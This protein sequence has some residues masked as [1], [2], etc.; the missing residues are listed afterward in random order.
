MWF[1]LIIVVVCVIA[2]M[3]SSSCDE[4]RVQEE[5]KKIKKIQKARDSLILQFISSGMIFVDTCIFMSKNR[6]FLDNF[7]KICIKNKIKI[8]VHNHVWGE[9]QQKKNDGDKKKA[10]LARQGIKV[11]HKMIDEELI[12]FYPK[13]IF[14]NNTKGHA[15]YADSN[16]EQ[17]LAELLEQGKEPKLLTN[18]KDLSTALQYNLKFPK[19]N[20]L[21]IKEWEDL[22]AK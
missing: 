19:S 17:D 11:I 6:D 9:L 3:D 10:Y 22:A 5:R 16:F 7:K 14:D 18:D 2:S 8:F 15:F 13:D 20:I 21:S 4:A 1:L 12:T